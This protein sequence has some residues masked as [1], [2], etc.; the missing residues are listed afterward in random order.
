MVM[1]ISERLKQ[2]RRENG[3]TQTELAYK[4]KIGQTTIASYENGTREPHIFSLIA[5]ADFFKC[6]IDYLTGREQNDDTDTIIAVT[7]EEIELIKTYRNL[8]GDLKKL[9]LDYAR[10]TGNSDLNKK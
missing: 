8:N 6:S 10:I 7:P 9:L 4:L 1:N 2:L 3:L 5:Y